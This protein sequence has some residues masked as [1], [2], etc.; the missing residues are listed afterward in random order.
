LTV[1]ASGPYFGN[2]WI[3]AIVKPFVFLFG[4][5]F[6]V[7][8][9]APAQAQIYSPRKLTQRIAPLLPPPP[10]NAMPRP[11]PTV[12]RSTST[13][14]AS[15]SPSRAAPASAKP[16]AEAEPPPARE[17]DPN[18]VTIDRV[19]VT[20]ECTALHPDPEE[21]LQTI[22]LCLSNTCS[23]AVK[24]LTMRLI[25]CDRAGE[26]LKEW[27]TRRELDQPLAANTKLD[28][29]QPGYFMPLITRE[30][31]VQVLGVRFAD[32]SAWPPGG[33]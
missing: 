20:V 6:A 16:L 2:S 29:A 13:L 14:Q 9:L 33:H 25:Y 3:E 4:A 21:S 31:K 17:P 18:L 8:I 23:K 27:T 12:P 28:L 7:S 22:G 5:L 15:V 32:G 26:R 30:V 11:A 19:P 1:T 10:S 24:S